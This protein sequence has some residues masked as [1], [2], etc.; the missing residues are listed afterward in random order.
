MV[1][2]RIET[3]VL[4]QQ[5]SIKDLAVI[6]DQKSCALIDSEGTVAWYC[7]WRFDQPS[8]FSL[9]VDREGGWWTVEAAG[10][11]L[12]QRDYQNDSAILVSEFDVEGGS[13]TVRDFMPTVPE[14]AGIC[15]LFSA[16]PVA[17]TSRLFPLPDYGRATAR[18][19]QDGNFLVWEDRF[20]F[21]IMGSHPL[22][23]LG[24]EVVMTI[25][26]GEESWCVLV[27]DKRAL[28]HLTTGELHQAMQQTEGRWKSIMRNIEYEGPYKK[29]FYQSYK[30]IQLVTHSGSGGIL[31]AAT[32]SLPEKIGG[33]RNYDYRYVWL[34]DTAMD[35]SA[36]IRAN[37]SGGE[38]ER[39]LD[40][41]CAG[42]NTNKKNLFV[43]FYDLDHKTAPDEEH[44]PGTGYRNST[45]LRIGNGAHEQLQLDA[46]GNVLLAA[47]QI[48]TKKG[49]KPHWETVM[50]TAE[51]LVENWR[52]KD[53]GIW[54]ENTEHHYTSSK[55]LVAKSFEFLAQYADTE[56][57]RIR[58][59]QAARDIRRF[60][61]LH[62]MTSDGA[63]AVYAGSESVDVTAALYGVWWYDKPDSPAMQQTIRRQETEYRDG[64]LYRR[65]LVE[66]SSTKEGVFL[67]GSL[68]MAQHYLMLNEIAKAEA[69]LQA[70]LGFATDLGFLPEEGD[71]KTGEALGNLPQTFVH[72]SLMGVI[73]DYKSAIEN[74]TNLL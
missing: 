26:P 58:W 9:L 14:M 7:L 57:Q 64:D 24:G 11:R 17:V 35:V 21:Y 49:G 61:N 47:K 53:H 20:E 23:L 55:V 46:Q 6:G 73:L 25:P 8:L 41:L 16:A 66:T 70:V 1:L 74:T 31:A 42:R 32:T 38:A 2:N 27:D 60:V 19:Q 28:P 69:I 59:L 13:F 33:S 43:P 36:L 40:F 12:R 15:R 71:V 54:E 48:Y 34:R 39:F 22:Q 29:A 52:K 3:A 56:P 18:L 68:W 5:P 30:A 4:P 44:I 67:A 10:K 50:G 63:Y 45:P 51:Y 37:S 72:A 62:C 65:H